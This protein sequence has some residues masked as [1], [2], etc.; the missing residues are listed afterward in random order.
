M[1]SFPGQAL[2]LLLPAGWMPLTGLLITAQTIITD[3]S[4]LEFLTDKDKRRLN[5]IDRFSNHHWNYRH[6]GPYTV[7][8]MN[9]LGSYLH[10]SLPIYNA[11]QQEHCLIKMYFCVWFLKTGIFQVHCD[12][13][14]QHLQRHHRIRNRPFHSHPQVNLQAFSFHFLTFTF[15]L[16]KKHRRPEKGRLSNFLTFTF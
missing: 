16:S 7:V 12:V 1:F 8:L 4:R 13:H 14:F 2:L 3:K 10:C 5:A 9:Y 6:C 15:S 11:S